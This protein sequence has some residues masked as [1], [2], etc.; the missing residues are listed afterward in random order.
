MTVPGPSRPAPEAEAPQAQQR[1]TALS[2]PSLT[3]LP[4]QASGGTSS[5]PEASTQGSEASEPQDAPQPSTSDAESSQMAARIRSSE[6]AQVGHAPQAPG[7]QAVQLL[8]LSQ[9][10]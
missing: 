1:M 9:H 8:Y 2:R 3:Q 4:S 6:P 5:A 7:T 10:S